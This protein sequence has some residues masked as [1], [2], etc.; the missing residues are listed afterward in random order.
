MAETTALEPVSLP[1]PAVC[2]Q[3][4]TWRL[5]LAAASIGALS[6]FAAALVRLSFRGLQWILTG[7]GADPPLAAAHLALWRRALTPVAGAL[8]ATAVLWARQR[9]AHRLGREPRPYVEY[10]EAVR[11]QHG[12]IP[13]LPNAWRTLSAAFSVASGAAVGRE[14]SMIQFA[15]AIA[16]AAARWRPWVGPQDAPEPPKLAFL[17]ACGVAG[18][19]TAAY[20][21]PIAAIF[22]AAEIVLGGLQWL[23][24]PLLALA[25]GTGWLVSGA[26][27]GREPLYPV[28]PA[29]TWNLHLLLL[30]LLALALGLA[31]PAYQKL[32]GSFRTARRLP[33]PLLWSGLTVGLLSM[34][35][36]RVWGNGDVGLRFALG[37]P[38]GHTQLPDTT[39]TPQNLL[40][41]VALRLLATCGCVWT[42]TVGGVFTPTLFLGG[43]LGALLSHFATG[44]DAPLWAV[45]GMSCFLAGVTHAPVMA[46]LMAAELTGDWTLVPLLL[47]LNLLARTV[48]R[49][50]SPRALYAV[51]SQSPVH[52]PGGTSAGVDK[53]H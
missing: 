4:W 7:S 30:P 16:S 50:L 37:H 51:A 47:P 34:L 32:L 3:R 14:G 1:E 11:H 10:V 41:I 33:L 26:L 53:L 42:G 19:V 13:L 22:F 20:N 8:L 35:D 52:A 21:A 18:G 12:A 15:A 9:R 45:A 17:V 29:L 40:H 24:L 31:G 36:P 2:I 39:M 6:A 27:L 28:H 44:A 43:A 46:T 38:L 48:A 5:V 49:R 23:E 25:A